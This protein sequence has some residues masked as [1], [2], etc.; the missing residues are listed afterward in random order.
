M[1]TI[2]EALSYENPNLRAYVFWTSILVLKMLLM[3]HLTGNERKKK[4]VRLFFGLKFTDCDETLIFIN[5]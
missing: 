3:S 5:L 1:T 4:K 2:L